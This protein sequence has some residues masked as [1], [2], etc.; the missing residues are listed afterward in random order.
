MRMTIHEKIYRCRRAKG[1]SQEDLAE[2][3]G[4]SRQS[5]SKWETGEGQ[6]ELG[7]LLPIANCFQVTTD[8]LLNDDAAFPYT[9][10]TNA[11]FTQVQPSASGNKA[12]YYYRKYGWLIG[13]AGIVYGLLFSAGVTPVFVA[14]TQVIKQD[15]GDAVSRAFL[16]VP[17][18]FAVVA[19]ALITGGTIFLVRFLKK[20]PRR[21]K[22]DVQDGS[23]QQKN[24][25]S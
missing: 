3:L 13:A 5:V 11:Q 24:D 22:Q 9:P 17:M 18:V 4:V 25:L 2:M 10:P 16:I 21:R 7:K 8:W 6:P 14:I 1:Y 23:Q 19:L 15:G 12:G 20:Y